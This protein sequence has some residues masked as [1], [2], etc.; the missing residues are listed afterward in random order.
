[1]LLLSPPLPSLPTIASHTS[2]SSPVKGGGTSLQHTNEG[3]VPAGEEYISLQHTSCEQLLMQKLRVLAEQHVHETCLEISCVILC[4]VI[5][6]SLLVYSMYSILSF[7]F[8]LSSLSS[9]V[10]LCYGV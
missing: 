4:C 9:R 8:S 7:L 1:M 6:S 2:R 5:F 10:A 3:E